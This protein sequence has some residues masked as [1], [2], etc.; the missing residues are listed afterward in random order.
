ML[1]SLVARLESYRAVPPYEKV[2]VG[3]SLLAIPYGAVPNRTY[4]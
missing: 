4:R 3:A 1:I 2:Y